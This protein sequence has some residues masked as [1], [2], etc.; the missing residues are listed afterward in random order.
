MVIPRG[1]GNGDFCPEHSLQSIFFRQPGVGMN[2]LQ[3]T[4]LQHVCHGG[5]RRVPEGLLNKVFPGTGTF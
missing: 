2:K 5:V 4:L 3:K 1:Y